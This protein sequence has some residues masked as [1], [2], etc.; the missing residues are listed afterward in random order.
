MRMS[1]PVAIWTLLLC[2]SAVSCSVR[3]MAE[4]DR[5]SVVF[6]ACTPAPFAKSSLAGHESVVESI[7]LFVFDIQDGNMIARA[8]GMDDRVSVLLPAR[9][10]LQYAAVLNGTPQP[11]F[12]NRE[13]FLSARADMSAFGTSSFLMIAEGEST[14]EKSSSVS[15]I[16]RRML[17]KVMVDSVSVAFDE[18][19]DAVLSRA[20]LINVCGSEP[21]SMAASCEGP[22]F[23]RMSL[24]PSLPAALRSHLLC[25]SC[26][27]PI[28]RDPACCDIALYCL[29]NPLDNDVT[30]EHE[31]AWSPR[32]TRLV[33]EVMLDGAL[34]YYALTFGGM[35]SNTC[36]RIRHLVLTGPGSDD[37]DDPHGGRFL[38]YEVS[39]DDWVDG[40]EEEIGL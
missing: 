17:C 28:G 23:N 10:R 2:F 20:Y 12:E 19:M 21:Y 27:M 40:R 35:K 15:L 37:P 16:A 11:T 6:K 7:D 34:H 3:D 36:Y 1:H 29:P 38:K 31:T 13:Q 32:S 4:E 14:F 25:D 30:S 33:L 9:Q 22:W 5:V 24:D 8:H 39:V 18:A 26:C